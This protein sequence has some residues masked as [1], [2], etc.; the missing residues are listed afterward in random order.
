[1]TRPPDMPILGAYQLEELLAE[2]SVGEVWRARNRETGQ[3]VAVKLITGAPSDSSRGARDF[4]DEIRH[5]AAL[6]HPGIVRLFDLGHLDEHSASKLGPGHR[7]GSPYLVMELASETLRE[8]TFPRDWPALYDVLRRILE[9]LAYAHANGLIHR[10][11]KPGNVLHFPARPSVEKLK[12][13]DF[14]LALADP[15]DDRETD[16][17]FVV[18][19]AGTPRYMAPEQCVGQWRMFGPWTDIYQVGVMAWEFAS[20]RPPFPPDDPLDVARAHVRFPRPPIAPE[21]AVP[22]SFD[23]W[24]QRMMQ[25]SPEERF[26][27]AAD[28]LNALRRLKNK[29]AN[30]VVEAPHPSDVSHQPDT[31]T[32]ENPP[33]TDVTTETLEHDVEPPDEA[34][35]VRPMQLPGP[36]DVPDDWRR[37]RDAP[38]EWKEMYGSNVTFDV[39]RLRSSP[40]VDRDDER[41][42]LWNAFRRAVDSQSLQ[43]VAA[44]GPP[45][46]GKSRLCRWI[47]SRG[48]ELGAADILHAP[49]QEG[50]GS[51]AGFT[52]MLERFFRTWGL[53][54]DETL[55]LIERRIATLGGSDAAGQARALTEWIRPASSG[56]DPLWYF[57]DY[58]DYYDTFRRFIVRLARRRPLMV[59]L[60]D[61]HWSPLAREWTTKLF[62]D[63]VDAP[64]LLVATSRAPINWAEE[65]ARQLIDLNVAPLPDA[66]HSEMIRE[67]MPL[68]E[69]LLGR[70]LNRAEG[71]PLFSIQMLDH[72][73]ES[74]LLEEGEA[75]LELKDDPEQPLPAAIHNLWERRVEELIERIVADAESSSADDVRAALELAAALG[76]RV[77]QDRWNAC[78]RRAGL[79]VPDD[80]SGWLKTATLAKP[81]PTGW[82]FEHSLLVDSLRRTS[83]EAGRWR[84]LNAVCAAELAED[85]PGNQVHLWDQLAVHYRE[86]GNIDQA[87][88]AL[89]GALGIV[90]RSGQAEAMEQILERRQE[91]IDR[92]PPQRRRLPQLRQRLETAWLIYHR[93]RPTEADTILDRL[94]DEAEETGNDAL[95]G[96]IL[97]ARMSIAGELGQVDRSLE[98]GEQAAA[99]LRRSETWEELAR[100]AYSRG[101]HLMI[102]GH[103]DEARDALEHGIELAERADDPGFRIIVERLLAW[104]DIRADHIQ[105]ARTRLE[106]LLEEA[107]QL[108]KLNPR[109]MCLNALGELESSKGN[110]HQAREYF[111]RELE[112]RDQHGAHASHHVS[113]I[114][115]GT[116]NLLMGRHRSAHRRYTEALDVLPDQ[117]RGL[118]SLNLYLGLLG[119]ACIEND[120][121]A[122]TKWLERATSIATDVDADPSAITD[123]TSFIR[124]CVQSSPSDDLKSRITTFLNQI[125]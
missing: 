23:G 5:Q 124:R 66:E 117:A 109:F 32:Q 3:P 2:G 49:H 47:A 34:D 57:N 103:D 76:R 116:I 15:A 88:D 91:L 123:L 59:F 51:D 101:F 74:D 33:P 52:E 18:P 97:R 114:N 110:Y 80:L 16:D 112:L 30:Y 36:P 40:F 69:T 22:R 113:L 95:L 96:R 10:D 17:E 45:G 64:I 27:R 106:R 99:Y 28:A 24:V 68:N 42:T 94:V 62:R 121:P 83:R 100:C 115:L 118:P 35:D 75:G 11:L 125:T 71:I 60:E 26:Q 107:E 31:T 7:D 21:F 73:V 65:V 56:E 12:L 37:D 44:H 90:R 85:G 79:D 8:S 93:G 104:L 111:R 39:F 29:Q 14:G 13:A 119:C 38:R 87:I 77:G 81:T 41:D 63:E 122:M 20:G 53:D 108:G 86:A 6:S 98:F 55:T 25:R 1:M 54:R 4:R 46:I 82:L 50:E 78:S 120:R 105:K 67:M 89:D 92:L 9:A 70:L 72:W 61:L 84:R 43:G 19:T 102:R 48:H 58:D